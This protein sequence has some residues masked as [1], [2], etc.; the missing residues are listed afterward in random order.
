MT[1]LRL[2]RVML[3]QRRDLLRDTLVAVSMSGAVALSTAALQAAL[4]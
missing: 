3:R 4:R 1:Y 2:N